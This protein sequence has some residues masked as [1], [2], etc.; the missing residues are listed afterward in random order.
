MDLINYNVK[1]LLTLLSYKR[2]TKKAHTTLK[3]IE[4]WK[5]KIPKNLIQQSDEYAKDVLGSKRYAPWLY[6]Y[7]VF[8]G[9][10][11][12]GWIPDNYYE[13]HIIPKLKGG[14]G[15][16]SSNRGLSKILFDAEFFPDLYYRINNLWFDNT[17]TSISN[18][19]L[20]KKL[21]KTNKSIF[22]N[23]SSARGEGVIIFDENSINTNILERLGN[24]VVQE[25]IR[26]HSFFDAIE[27]NSIATIRLTSVSEEN[28]SIK[29]VAA[30]L[31]VGRSNDKVVKSSSHIRVPISIDTGELDEFAYD[32]NW[33]QISKHPDS[34]YLF[35]KQQI[36]HYDKCIEAVK[37]LHSKIPFVRIIGWDLIVDSDGKVQVMEWNGKHNDI[38][39]SEA[40][41]GP[42]FKGMGFEN[43]WKKS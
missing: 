42:I 2:S 37:K 24:G 15:L 16:L 7:S 43:L 5:G 8:N 30:Y 14:Y 9:E 38:K 6:V 34:G 40:T 32:T 12:E 26:Q 20:H 1:K 31:R 23:D 41:Q 25:F 19:N 10:F 18:E 27:Q 11:K 35:S 13:E 4:L 3:N 29:I 21:L 28:G 22:K 39:F 33:L 36:P 17:Y